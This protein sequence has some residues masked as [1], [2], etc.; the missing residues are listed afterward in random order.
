MD[1]IR[2]RFL[3]SLNDIGWR[4]F[5]SIPNLYPR[6]KKLWKLR[7]QILLFGQGMNIK[8][9]TVKSWRLK[10][11]IQYWI[12]FSKIN[13]FKV[14]FVTIN[15]SQSLWLYKMYY[16]NVKYQLSV[17]SLNS[18]QYL[19]NFISFDYL[20]SVLIWKKKIYSVPTHLL[21]A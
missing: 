17:I 20:L 3:E 5:S 8:I 16:L 12:F 7:L 9:F 4:F 14:W 18:L 13:T 19:Q 21:R 15:V 11:S 2:I 1:E 10:I 6:S